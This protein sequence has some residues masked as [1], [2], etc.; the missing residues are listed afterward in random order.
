MYAPIVEGC[1]AADEQTSVVPVSVLT[2]SEKP[3]ESVTNLINCQHEL[4][5]NGLNHLLALSD[6]ASR[7]DRHTGRVHRHREHMDEEPEST[8]TTC[9]GISDQHG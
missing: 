1:M 5:P 3:C 7:T 6:P 8:S 2:T 9:R 4:I